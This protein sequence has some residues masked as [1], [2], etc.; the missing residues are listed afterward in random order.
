MYI[1]YLYLMM[2]CLKR[3]MLKNSVWQYGKG[4][5]GIR[6]IISYSLNFIHKLFDVFFL[7][8]S[9]NFHEVGF[10]FFVVCLSNT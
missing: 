5:E 4:K 9:T 3:K 10:T 8:P 2:L 6:S 1:C 7:M